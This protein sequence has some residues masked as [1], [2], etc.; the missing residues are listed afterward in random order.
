[1]SYSTCKSSSCFLSSVHNWALL[2][3]TYLQRGRHTSGRP[4]VPCWSLRPS[5]TRISTRLDL[6]E[7]PSLGGTSPLYLTWELLVAPIKLLI[8]SGPCNTASFKDT[9]LCLAAQSNTICILSSLKKIQDWM[10][11]QIPNR[12]VPGLPILLTNFLCIAFP[13]E[14]LYALFVFHIALSL[15]NLFANDFNC[16]S[17]LHLLSGKLG[18]LLL[19]GTGSWK[20]APLRWMSLSQISITFL[21]L[22]GIA[23]SFLSTSVAPIFQNWFTCSSIQTLLSMK[24]DVALCTPSE[25]EP[26]GPLNDHPNLV[27]TA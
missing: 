23:L 11:G 5:T 21:S 1:M 6:L 8:E 22:T 20:C 7:A 25:L 16:C 13:E 2:G 26:T 3:S 9:P 19:K 14:I 4:T 15:C 12:G 10:V 27:V 17:V 18:G 24:L